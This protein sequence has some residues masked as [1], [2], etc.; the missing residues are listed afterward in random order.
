LPV[1]YPYRES[2]LRQQLCDIG[3]MLYERGFIGAADGNLAVRLDPERLL[4]TP[5][6]ELKGFMTPESMVVTDLAGQPLDGGR[7]STEIQ[8]HVAVFE[9]RPDIHAVV[10]AHPPHS[11]AFS[12]AG[13]SMARCVIP[14]IVVTIGMVP[15]V[16][17]ATPGTE[18]LPHSIREPIRGADAVILERHGS[19]TVGSELWDAFR[20]LDMVE[21]AS[22][23]THLAATL[24]T[25]VKVLNRDQVDRLMRSRREMG[26]PGKNTICDD[27]A[28][29]SACSHPIFP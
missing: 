28:A 14:E 13:V 27:C 16:P 22:H 3:R 11:V 10:H 19:I 7:P 9:E 4:V 2:E 23:I 29:R 8:M 1:D 15:T 6:G 12:I 20:V 25:E 24:G 5:S 17:Y 18:E 26:M 21:H